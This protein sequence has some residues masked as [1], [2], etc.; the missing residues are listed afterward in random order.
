MAVYVLYT[1]LCNSTL[2]IWLWLTPLLSP[3][4]LKT[5]PPEVT[6]PAHASTHDFSAAAL[7]TALSSIGSMTLYPFIVALWPRRA[8]SGGQRAAGG[9]LVKMI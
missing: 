3:V 1:H 4:G 9:G 8:A 6:G 2:G 7:V 5:V